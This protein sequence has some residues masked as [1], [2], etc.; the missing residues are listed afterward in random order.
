MSK[1]T[2]YVILSTLM[3]GLTIATIAVNYH[4]NA[5]GITSPVVSEAQ[6]T[7]VIEENE[8][9]GDSEPFIKM[10]VS[11]IELLAK[12]VYGEARGCS[13]IEQSAVIW[14]IL[15]RVDASGDTIEEVVTAKYQFTGY[16]SEHPVTFEF[17]TLAEDVLAR[18]IMEKHC[19]GEVGRTLP[20]EYQWFIGNGKENIF[21]DKYDGDYTIWDWN[22][23]NPYL[24]I[25]N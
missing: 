7:Q 16:N 15:N 12:T 20:S 25:Q 3:I 9:E 8:H 6:D 1:R 17:Y 18:W 23:Y 2:Y 13:R 4:T 5:E 10:N 24:T 14:C 22:C 19:I 11:D 21:R